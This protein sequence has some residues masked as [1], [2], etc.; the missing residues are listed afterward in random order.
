MHDFSALQ[1][2]LP[3]PLGL[4]VRVTDVKADHRSFSAN[5]A[6]PCQ[7]GHLR[8]NLYILNALC[9]TLP[10]NQINKGSTTRPNI[11]AKSAG[12]HFSGGKTIGGEVSTKPLK[13]SFLPRKGGSKNAFGALL[14]RRAF[15]L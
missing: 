3:T 8:I 7:W 1:V 13:G 2:R 14:W 6:N 11:Q 9:Y 15:R 4:I 5:I 12:D 10:T